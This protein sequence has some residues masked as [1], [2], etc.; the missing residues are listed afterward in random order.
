MAVVDGSGEDVELQSRLL[1]DEG[2]VARLDVEGDGRR[3]VAGDLVADGDRD[4]HDR[5]RVVER[6]AGRVERD[7]HVAEALE[8]R[9]DPHGAAQRIRAERDSN[10]S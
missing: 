3:Q 6:D 7:A 10:G 9:C 5:L 8:S 1:G 2:P 4:G